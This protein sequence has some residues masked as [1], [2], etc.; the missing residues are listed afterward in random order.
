VGEGGGRLDKG[1]VGLGLQ[2]YLPGWSD[3]GDE[4]IYGDQRLRQPAANAEYHR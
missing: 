2:E 3:L 1:S 4:I